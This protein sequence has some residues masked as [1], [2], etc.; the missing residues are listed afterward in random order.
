M[1]I[2]DR[3]FIREFIVPLLFCLAAFFLIY[4]I[5]DLSA[6]LDDYIEYRIPIAQLA[7]YYLIQL[8]MVM[9]QLIPLSIL[10][11]I[12]YSIGLMSRHNEIIAMR[13][14]GVS[15]LG[16]MRPFF[17]IGIFFT[18][19]LF[20]LNEQFAPQAFARSER[21]VEE[22]S[23]RQEKRRLRP[24]AF[25]NPLAERTW[26]GQWV[27]GD[28][29]L[30]QATI[31][32][33]HNRQVVEKISAQRASYLDGE[34]WL[35]DGAIQSYDGSGHIRGQEEPFGKRRFPF[36][37]KPEDFLSSQKDSLS[38]NFRELGQ[39]MAFYPPDSEIFGRKLVDLHYKVALPFV[40]ITIVLIAVPLALR[41][42]RSG[43]AGSAGVSIA[44]GISYYA[45]LTISLAMGRGGYLPPWLASWVPNILFGTT[46]AVLIYK[47][48]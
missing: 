32:N 12:V 24:I 41:S 18:L 29:T 46:G 38:M 25:Y 28:A 26:A 22:W 42:S 10:L 9:V 37:E 45:L 2:I 40:A 17:A 6:H 43:A 16:I 48:R 4:I 13:A 21:L 8:P 14:A 30:Q 7:G 36:K 5:Y 35:F 39:N 11:A 23:H 33:L 15:I 44:L 27:P 47:S 3:Y 31:R 1:K 20:Y 34:W 19:L